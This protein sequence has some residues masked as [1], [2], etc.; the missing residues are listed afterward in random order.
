MAPPPLPFSMVLP[1]IVQL[2]RTAVPWSA[3]ALPPP[4]TVEFPVNVH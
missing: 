3:M 1:L 4:L 2:V